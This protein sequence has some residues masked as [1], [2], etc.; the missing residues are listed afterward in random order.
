M[1]RTLFIFL[2]S[3]RVDPYV[4][5]IVY[6]YDNMG[7][8]SVRLVYVRGTRTGL[9]ESEASAAFN[10]VWS[11][12]E[13]LA[14]GNAEVYKRVNE[15]LLDRQLIPVDYSD[16][17]RSL[18]HL[19]KKHG[20]PRHCVFDLTGASKTPSIG[21]FAVCLAIGVK[22]VYTFELADRPD[23]DDPDSFLYHA[24]DEEQYSYTCLTDTEP[25]R[26]SQSALLRKTSLFWYIFFI[27]LVVMA[28]SLYTLVVVSPDNMMVQ[29]LN[30]AAA[31][32]GLASPFFALI[33]QRRGC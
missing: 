29:S 16:L 31:V 19:V 22:S 7:V 15:R 10:Q 26:R 1:N 11:R 21:V 28:V 27:S 25:V 4:N 3:D 24:L 20:G 6:A 30:L 9:T 12:V 14:A 18:S 8:T 23:P 17:K 13:K 32:V 33:Q 5:A 2:F